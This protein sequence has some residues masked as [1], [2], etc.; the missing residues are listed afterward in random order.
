MIYVRLSS[1]V[2]RSKPFAVATVSVAV[3][4]PTANDVEKVRTIATMGDTLLKITDNA[5]LIL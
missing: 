3:S 2:P 4:I 5:T 1:T